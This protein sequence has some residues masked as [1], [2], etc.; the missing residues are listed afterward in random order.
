MSHMLIII[1]STVG[2]MQNTFNALSEKVSMDTVLESIRTTKFG[3]PIYRSLKSFLSL[4]SGF[5]TSY[6]TK[7]GN[8]FLS[9]RIWTD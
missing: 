5:N 3:T 7:L 2:H 4:V 8:T 9:V 6:Y 1:L